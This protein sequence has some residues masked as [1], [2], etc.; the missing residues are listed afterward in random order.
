MRR[1]LAAATTLTAL[2]ALTACSTGP[3]GADDTAPTLS[4][5]PSVTATAEAPTDTAAGTPITITADGQTFTATLNDSQVSQDFIATLP[6]T[7]DWYRNA[8]IEYITELPEPMTETG[9]FYTN[10]EAGDLVYY[11]PM[12]SITIIYEPTSSVPT[13]TKMGEITSDLNA[14]QDLPDDVEMRIELE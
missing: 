11:N 8:G 4:A 1:T 3:S 12:D 10:V 9:P 2:L 7:L 13:L 5:T 14:F 6:V